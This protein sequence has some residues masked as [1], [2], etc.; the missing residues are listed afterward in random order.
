MPRDTSPARP[1]LATVQRWIQGIVVHP[2]SVEAAL[3]SEPVARE[4]PP[5]HLEQVVLPS[6]SLDP[7]GRL[8]VYRGMYLLRMEEALRTDD[9]AVAW[10]LGDDK[11][12]SMV[13]AYVGEFPSRSYTLNRLGDHLPEYLDRSG[14]P[15]AAF[16][17]DLARFE[18]AITRVFD[19]EETGVLSTEALQAIAPEQWDGLRLVP[20]RAF[21][22]VEL[23][24]DV[25]PHLKAYHG[26]RPSP[27]PRR[28]ATR[29]AVFRRNLAVR[30]MEL[31][32]P[33]ATL[34]TALV[35]GMPLGDALGEALADVRSTRR[36]QAVFRWF[37]EWVS[38]GLFSAAELA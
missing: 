31:G 6:W 28:R 13:E 17:A 10:H 21:R 36:Q 23:R 24:H 27:R 5:E 34:L 11:F 1:D 12:S 38:E 15:D 29:I 7:A 2:V 35:E 3:S 18:L 37:R 32:R 19:E 16:L 9:P 30:H 4:I 26:Q 8:E 22:L 25:V 14:L 20:I 33:Q